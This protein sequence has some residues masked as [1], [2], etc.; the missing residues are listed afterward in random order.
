MKKNTLMISLLLAF[1]L[2]CGTNDSLAQN[3]SEY[4]EYY[5]DVYGYIANSD[6]RIVTAIRE[7]GDEVHIEAIAIGYVNLGAFTLS[8]AYDPKMVIPIMGQGGIDITISL[9]TVATMNEFIWINPQLPYAQLWKISASGNLKMAPTGNLATT[10]SVATQMNNLATTAITI[11]SSN[12][13]S[14]LILQN[15]EMMTIFKLFF[16]KLNQ[17]PLTENTFFYKNNTE[18]PVQQNQFYKGAYLRQE[19]FDAPPAINLCPKMFTR[20]SPATITALNANVKENG[21]TL[22]ALANAE[23]IAKQTELYQLLNWD[24]IMATGFIYSKNNVEIAIDQYAKKINMDGAEYD[25]PNVA[26]GSFNLGNYTFDMIAK[27]NTN[28][29]TQIFMEETIAELDPEEQYYAYPFMIYKFQTSNEYPELGNRLDFTTGVACTTR[30]TPTVT[31]NPIAG[32]ICS[33]E[34]F[35]Y[36]ITTSFPVT[37]IVWTR[38]THPNINNNATITGNTPNIYE[39]LNNNGNTE[40]TVTYSISLVADDCEYNNVA[41]V[42][43]NVLPDINFLFDK[44][45]V[46]CCNAKVLNLNYLSNVLNAEYKL[47][48]SKIGVIS[49]FINVN[50]YIPLPQQ[51]IQII[52]PQNVTPGEYPATL[53]IRYQNCEKN[54]NLVIRIKALPQIITAK[55]NNLFLKEHEEFFLFEETDQ[56]VTYQWYFNNTPIENA[57]NFYYSDLFDKTKEGTFSVKLTNECA[58]KTVEF[59]LQPKLNIEN[60]ATFNDYKL[61]VYPNP[62]TRNE[63]FMIVLETPYNETPDATANILD[64]NGKIVDELKIN[65]IETQTK[66]NVAEGTYFIRVTTKSGKELL[67]KIIVKQ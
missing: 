41:E 28:E 25:F 57:T 29:E 5:D 43:V 22:T 39:I 66:L 26:N 48:F 11:G 47:V 46:V 59:Y 35:D 61:S 65:K 19:G 7:I 49:G 37:E 27:M 32:T 21:V 16:R 51:Y 13:A 33:G 63:I 3:S 31:C 50:Q 55:T 23:G 62:T 6:A 54:Y 15:G 20:R 38:I 56:D 18:P 2:T 52:I 64:A 14:N 44:E 34:L 4:F 30:P 58:S 40:T 12:A 17:R 8:L 60:D 42:T 36:P 45:P 10:R 9:P 24:N 53:S 67:T 1:L